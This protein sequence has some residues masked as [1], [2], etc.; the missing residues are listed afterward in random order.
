VTTH[1]D[2]TERADRSSPSEA[3]KSQCAIR[4]VG[5]GKAYRLY[6]R[7]SDFLKEIIT[8]KSR[9]AKHW[10]L[11][12]VSFEI[13]RGSVVG[14]IGPNGAGKSTLLRIIAGLLDATTGRV[15][16]A[17]RLSAILE[18]GTG[19]HPDVSGRDNIVLGGMCLGMTR[20]EV[21]AKVPWVIGFSELNEV[22]DQP[23]RTYS[24]GMQARLTFATA[25]SVDP[26]VFIVDE[27]LAAG[28]TSFVNKCMKR[29]REICESGATVLLVSHSSGL[30]GELCDEAIWIDKGRILL[31]GNAQRVS[32][33]YEQSVWDRQEAVN[34]EVTKGLSE[35][36]RRTADTGSY[37]LGGEDLR[38][39][40]VDIVDLQGRSLGGV[41]NGDTLRI[42]ISWK[43][44][45]A[46]NKIYCSI[47]ID[48]NRIQ[49]VAGVEGYD[50]GAFL[51]ADGSINETGSITY[52]IPE[53][54]LGEG[55]YWVSASICRHLLPKG[56]EAILHY[57]EKAAQ[58][59][60]FRNSLWHVA[61]IY[62][63]KYSWHV[64]RRMTF[65]ERS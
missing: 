1:L 38:I 29:V 12:N 53:L 39:T 43:G 28:D 49:A 14:I 41:K 4:V 37:E 48:S 13:P 32:K 34:L 30:I 52:E 36:I 59:S 56:S 19:F 50:L 63:P 40:S 24:S 11:E 7:R 26:E 55:T 2:S 61:Y 8:G 35:S 25:I 62:D 15:E 9:H 21:E 64:E 33:A 31:K 22:I 27:A 3:L 10:A 5:L 57:V 47:R 58:F 51:D 65:D 60:V 16:V 46:H 54:A 20:A 42:K 44:K 18:L 23:F 45:T 6:Q 17:G